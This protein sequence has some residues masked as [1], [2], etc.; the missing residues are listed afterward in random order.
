MKEQL[1]KQQE[2]ADKKRSSGVK[3]KHVKGTPFTIVQTE[4]IVQ[5]TIGSDVVGNDYKSIKEAEEA[6]NNKSWNLIILA[7]AV[8]ANKMTEYKQRNKG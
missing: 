3:H 7:A 2:K 8:I 5:I 4:G 6:I 1:L